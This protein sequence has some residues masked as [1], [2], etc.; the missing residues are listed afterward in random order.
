MITNAV[1]IEGTLQSDGRIV[2][3]QRPKN[4]PVGRVRVVLQALADERKGAERLPDAPW[5]DESIS[6]PF[7]LPRTGVVER[8][9][10][11]AIAERLPEVWTELAEDA[12]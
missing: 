10:P 1:E 12:R 9:R 2:L 3:D 8:V 7:D 5:L 6:A 11:N 4:I